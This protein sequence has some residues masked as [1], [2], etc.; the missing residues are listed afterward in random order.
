MRC[1][2]FFNQL[3]AK[4]TE[5]GHFQQDNA[6]AHTA[7]AIMVA[8]LEVFEDRIISRGLWPP[9][10]QFLR[11]LSLGKLKGKSLQELSS[12]H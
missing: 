6:T 9:R 1:D 8:V 2:P 11:F 4:E 5:H 12:Q 3:T 10:S 7:N